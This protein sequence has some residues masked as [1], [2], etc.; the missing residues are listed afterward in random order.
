MRSVIGGMQ[1]PPSNGLQ[2][3]AKE[4]HISLMIRLLAGL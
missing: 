2:L 4:S 1:Q 3:S